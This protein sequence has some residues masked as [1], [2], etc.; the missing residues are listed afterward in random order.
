ML[1]AQHLVAA[2]QRQSRVMRLQLREAVKTLNLSGISA[3]SEKLEMK[4]AADR[5]VDSL[6]AACK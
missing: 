5:Q 2:L 3:N 1:C 4:N 6:C